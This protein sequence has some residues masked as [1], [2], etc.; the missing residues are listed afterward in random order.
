MSD[1]EATPGRLVQR[2]TGSLARTV[3]RDLIHDRP[4]GRTVP[5]DPAATR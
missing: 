1:V 5:V 4:G 3:Q 2:I